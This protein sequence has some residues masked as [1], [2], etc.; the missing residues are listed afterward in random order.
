MSESVGPEIKSTGTTASHN[1]TEKNS[2]IVRRGK[3]RRENWVLWGGS[4]P[5]VAEMRT[6]TMGATGHRKLP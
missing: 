6:R 5:R 3:V 1:R 2:K 4:Q